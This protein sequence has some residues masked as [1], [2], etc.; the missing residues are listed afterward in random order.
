MNSISLR[1]SEK[2]CPEIQGPFHC[3]LRFRA[4]KI[5]SVVELGTSLPLSMGSLEA[6]CPNSIQLVHENQKEES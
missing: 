6:G 2:S 4:T 1:I 3:M 5:A